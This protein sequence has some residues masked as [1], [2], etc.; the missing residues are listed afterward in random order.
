MKALETSQ[1]PNKLSVAYR[2]V[3]QTDE[4][5]LLFQDLA[6]YCHF[7]TPCADQ[8]EEGKRRVFLHIQAMTNVVELP[9]QQEG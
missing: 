2:K 8:L 6:R 1:K 4:G 9:E 5:K 7:H 3:W